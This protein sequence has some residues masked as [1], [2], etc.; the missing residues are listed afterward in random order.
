MRRWWGSSTSR[1]PVS[2]GSEPPGGRR[3]SPGRW[4]GGSGRGPV[5]TSALAELSCTSPEMLGDD[6]PRWQKLAALVRR[7]YWGGD[8]YAYGLLA[9]GQIDVIVECDLKPW[10]WAALLPVIVGAGGVVTDWQGQSASG[11]GR[12]AGDRGGRS[13]VIAAGGGGVGGFLA[14]NRPV[15]GLRRFAVLRHVAGRTFHVMALPGSNGAN[16]KFAIPDEARFRAISSLFS[17]ACLSLGGECP[18]CGGMRTL[19]TASRLTCLPGLGEN[20]NLTCDCGW[21][22]R[23]CGKILTD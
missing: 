6:L 7:N 21:A 12:R 19:S 5:R 11:R 9:L 13:G 8:C 20:V 15:V 14:R 4:G 3:P 17:A 16:L 1:S 2:A 18:E 10:D 22:G 23:Q